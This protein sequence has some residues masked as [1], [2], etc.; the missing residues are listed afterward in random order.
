MKGLV[1][2]AA[3]GLAAG[4]PAA[5][6]S[7]PPPVTVISP[8]SLTVRAGEAKPATVTVRNDGADAL[9]LKLRTVLGK[10]TAKV[11]PK[12][13]TVRGS[14]VRA[15]Q[16]TITADK[17]DRDTTGAVVLTPTAAP[18][19]VIPLVIEPE[20]QRDYSAAVLIFLPLLL[21]ALL[22]LGRVLTVDVRAPFGP[23]NWN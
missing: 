19:G 10:G 17:S 7:A 15:F 20:K 13:L 23:A 16:I 2:L 9:T 1:I 3:L 4:L 8:D 11:K 14:K 6:A 12:Q 18:P 5:A 21:G 22:V